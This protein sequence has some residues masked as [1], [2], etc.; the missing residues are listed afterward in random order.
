MNVDKHS[1]IFSTDLIVREMFTLI[2]V[3]YAVFV[4]E[5]FFI[6]ELKVKGLHYKLIN[7]CLT[8]W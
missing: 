7:Y 5:Y 4:P 1:V 3:Q 2:N 8:V 6:T